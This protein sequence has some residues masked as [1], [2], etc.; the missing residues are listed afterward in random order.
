MLETAQVEQVSS[1]L[2]ERAATHFLHA[3]KLT[4][5][6][7][8]A[9]PRKGGEGVAVATR[10]SSCQLAPCEQRARRAAGSC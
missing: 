4:D 3:G 8:A 10:Q 9:M 6:M 1:R 2:G 7:L 5:G